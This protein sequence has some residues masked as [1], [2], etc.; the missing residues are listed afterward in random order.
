M[1]VL[2]RVCHVFPPIVSIFG[3]FLFC[4]CGDGL[5]DCHIINAVFDVSSHSFSVLLQFCGVIVGGRH[6]KHVNLSAGSVS[7]R[8]CG[9]VARLQQ[10]TKGL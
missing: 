7:R 9:L 8:S 10:Q 1:S 4:T 3:L 6:F 5:G 2:C